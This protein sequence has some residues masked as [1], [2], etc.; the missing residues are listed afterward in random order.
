MQEVTG[1]LFLQYYGE[2]V[3]LII[4]GC[5]GKLIFLYHSPNHVPSHQYKMAAPKQYSLGTIHSV[6]KITILI[7]DKIQCM[8]GCS[9][10]SSPLFILGLHILANG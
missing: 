8:D 1:E 9:S 2:A 7:L 10:S 4:F 3:E 5:K 6:G